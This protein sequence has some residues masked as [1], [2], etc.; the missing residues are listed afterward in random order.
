MQVEV[1]NL[2]VALGRYK[3]PILK[4]VDFFAESGQV[5]GL[6][7][8]NGS[9][10]STLLRCIYRVLDY[11]EGQ[12]FING[13]ELRSMPVRESAQAMAVLAQQS[14]LSFDFTVEKI[15]M[16]GRYP[17][18]NALESENQKDR[19]LVQESLELVNMESYKN[20]MFSSLSG[21][22]KQRVLLAR[23]LAQDT[24]ILILDEPT[25]HLDI[26]HQLQI[27]EL[28]Q[29]LNKTVI[30]AIHDLNVAA[31][32]CDTLFALKSGRVVASGKSDEILNP[33]L[34]KD[35]YETEAERVRDRNGNPRI[36]FYG[37][38]LSG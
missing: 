34:I 20:R 29:S 11:Q 31:Q 3:V 30:T 16:M 6:I 36:F 26:R 10:K 18:K 32:Y 15:V 37:N 22:E 2:S 24:P 19:D 27:M 25:N 28:C 12:V 7:G 21:G 13:K 8:P 23:A 5:T 9:G 14:K 4:H 35:L 33:D 17:Y 1:K 38:Q